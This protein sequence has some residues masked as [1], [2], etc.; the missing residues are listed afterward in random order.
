M[1]RGESH[2][3]HVSESVLGR[4][5]TSGHPSP[6]DT[7]LKSSILSAFLKSL[8]YLVR[9][10]LCPHLDLVHVS[11]RESQRFISFGVRCPL[12]KSVASLESSGLTTDLASS[13][14]PQLLTI[15]ITHK[16]TQMEEVFN[17]SNQRTHK[18]AEIKTRKISGS[19]PLECLCLSTPNEASVPAV[20]STS[21]TRL[22]HISFALP[23]FSSMPSYLRVRFHN[24]DRIN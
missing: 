12:R 4:S 10:Q 13:G 15:W 5:R 6:S 9:W 1:K 23:K 16:H 24:T 11:P 18:G 14:P 8:G 20:V 7:A 17:T 2:K 3:E 21:K 22:I 19:D